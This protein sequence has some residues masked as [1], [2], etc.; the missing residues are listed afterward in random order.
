M[1]DLSR[2][3]YQKVADAIVEKIVN[4]DYA[5]GKRVPSERDLAEEMQVSRPT[6]REA[7]IALEIRGFVDSRHGSGIYVTENPPVDAGETELDIGP[8]EL[9]EARRLFEGEAAALAASTIT[10]EEIAELDALIEGMSHHADSDAGERADGNFH[11]LIAAATRNTAIANVIEN[12]WGLRYKS[13]LCVDIFARGRR[14]G[15]HQPVDDHRVILDALRARDPNAA[16][17][18]MHA[19]LDNVVDQVLEATETDAFER[20]RLEVDAKRREFEQRS[21]LYRARKERGAREDA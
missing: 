21:K 10:D 20:A 1:T 17:E 14:A 13:P 11:V 8:F 5:P 19:H 6:I 12:L 7:M 9:I 16:R 15:V 18:A 4:G 2:K 3:L